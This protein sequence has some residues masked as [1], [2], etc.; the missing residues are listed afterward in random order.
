[1][2]VCGGGGTGGE[3]G[4]QKQRTLFMEAFLASTMERFHSALNPTNVF[5]LIDVF[6]RG[7]RSVTRCLLALIK[8]FYC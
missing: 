8:S 5:R 6:N 4:E 1:M 2:C 7:L 3:G